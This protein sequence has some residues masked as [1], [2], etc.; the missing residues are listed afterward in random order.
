MRYWLYAFLIAGS[1]MFSTGCATTSK[2]EENVSSM[3]W[4]RPQSWEGQG[5]LGGMHQ[6]GSN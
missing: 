2:D 5:Q 3:P 1:V 6:P 4:N